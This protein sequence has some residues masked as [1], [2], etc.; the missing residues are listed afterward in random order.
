MGAKLIYPDGKIK[1]V[2]KGKRLEEFL[3]EEYLCGKIGNEIVDFSYEIKG[4]EEIIL[5]DF[6]SEEGKLA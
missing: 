1:N 4:N 6:N 3:N 5:C 2:E